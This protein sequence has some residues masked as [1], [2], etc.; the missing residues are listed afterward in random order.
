MV[1]TR[2][3]NLLSYFRLLSLSTSFFFFLFSHA[4]SF[5]SFAFLSEEATSE[6]DPFK[7]FFSI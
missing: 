7:P 4:F 3:L 5:I 6:L 1:Q 2:F